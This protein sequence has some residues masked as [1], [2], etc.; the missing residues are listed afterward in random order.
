MHIKKLIKS[1]V[2]WEYVPF[3]SEKDMGNYLKRNLKVLSMGD[4]SP[5]SLDYELPCEKAKDKNKKSGKKDGRLD[6]LVDYEAFA[7]VVELKN[8]ELNNDHLN[9]LKS[10]LN[11]KIPVENLSDRGRRNIK[12]ILVG[13]SISPEL[14]V[15]LNKKEYK[16]EYKNRVSVITFKRYGYEDHEYEIV[17][18]YYPF[19]LRDYSKYFIENDPTPYPK[20]RIVYACVTDFLKRHHSVTFDALKNKVEVQ[21]DSI[22]ERIPI[23]LDSERLDSHKYKWAYYKKEPISLGDNKISFVVRNWWDISEEHY[24]RKVAENLGC[25]LTIKKAY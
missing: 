22:T 1:N 16:K 19:S 11:G 15:E 10:Y 18:I 5:I 12:G 7:A 13:S 2:V 14:L 23:L 17:D 3:G 6:F 24:I 9:Q 4:F 21:K 20:S 8:G 25:N